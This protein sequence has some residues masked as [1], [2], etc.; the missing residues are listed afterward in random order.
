MF[1]S[2]GYDRDFVFLADDRRRCRFDAMAVALTPPLSSGASKSRSR[3]S[4]VA[5][6]ASR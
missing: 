6:L 4:T 1:F 3:L 2:P 5:I